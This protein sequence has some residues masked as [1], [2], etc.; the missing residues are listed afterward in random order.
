MTKS[1]L[2]F[3]IKRNKEKIMGNIRQPQKTTSI[4]KKNRIIQAGLKAFTDKGYYNTTTAEI[5]KIAGVSTGIVYSYFKDKKDVFLHAIDLYFEKLY[6]PVIE[7]LQVLDFHNLE[8][9]LKTIIELTTA[10]HSKNV[11]SHEEFV[12]M[13]HL[14]EDVHNQF[15]LAEHKLTDI[16]CCI[17]K[18]NKINISDMN[19]KI[20]IA[21]NLIESY[22]HEYIFHKHDFIDYNKMKNETIKIILNLIEN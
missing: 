15:M 17:L 7:K 16:I 12:A 18:D 5:A 4:E 1:I 2:S 19:E 13:S 14:D 9:A 10:S 8:N 22:C 3:I 6:N 11:S 21:Y 20:H